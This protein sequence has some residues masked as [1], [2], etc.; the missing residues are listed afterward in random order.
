M[1]GNIRLIT[2]ADLPAVV[3]IQDD[4]YSDDLYEAPS[5]LQQ[6]IAMQPN[7]CWLIDN[8]AGAVVL[9]I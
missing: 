8:S 3:N 2:S 5:L 6:R 4:C 9:T 1:L 7:C